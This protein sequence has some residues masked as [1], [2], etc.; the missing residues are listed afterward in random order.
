MSS[1]RTRDTAPELK[2]RRALWAEGL[3]YRTHVRIEGARPDLA[4]LG[5][6]LVVFVDG[7]FW[8]GCPRH[9]VAPVE[10]A[11][12]WH[13]KVEKNK[14]RDARNNKVLGALGFQVV[15]IWE[16]EIE[17]SMEGVVARIQYLLG[18]APRARP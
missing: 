12:F 17:K 15:R 4:F 18:R 14:A 9:F 11:L 10:N 2:L 3:R 6:R 8:H 7:C 1:V 5:P 16:C 13:T